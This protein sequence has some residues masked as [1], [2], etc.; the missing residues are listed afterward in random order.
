MEVSRS[1]EPTDM[2]NT[3]ATCKVT[4]FIDSSRLPSHKIIGLSTKIN[5]TNCFPVESTLEQ[6]GCSL[7]TMQP[8]KMP[9]QKGFK[10]KVEVSVLRDSG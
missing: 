1:D 6:I 3:V 4:S 5:D 9:I 7:K 2:N 8:D 10:G